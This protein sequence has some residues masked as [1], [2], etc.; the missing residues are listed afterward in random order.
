MAQGT[1]SKLTDRG[2][3]FIKQ[4]DGSELFFHRSQVAGDGFDG[5]AV[6]QSV[7]YEKGVSQRSSKE[8]AQQVTPA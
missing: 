1:I 5:L 7:T 8:E 3:G 6:G 4:E 2:F